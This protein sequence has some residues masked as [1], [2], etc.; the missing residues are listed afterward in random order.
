M[1]WGKG[2]SFKKRIFLG[3][4]LAAMA[5]L[6]CS[7]VTSLLLF[8]ASADREMIEGGT[9]QLASAKERFFLMLESC[10]AACRR[11][12]ENGYTAWAMIDNKTIDWQRDLYLAMYQEAEKSYHDADYSIYDVGGQL[13][14]TTDPSQKQERLP[15]Q[16]GILRKASEQEGMVCSRTEPVLDVG[17]SKSL[18]QAA[19][20]LEGEN[21]VK[22]GYVVVDFTRESLD[23]LLSG[24]L[25]PGNTLL[26]LDSHQRPIYCSNQSYGNEQIQ[27]IISDTRANQKKHSSSGIGEK[28]LWVKEP[29]Y[30]FYILMCCSSLVSEAT[31]RTMGTVS[32]ILS[33]LG[34]GISFVIAGALSRSMGKPVSQLDRAMARVKEGDFS[35][36]ISSSRQDELGRLTERFNEMTGD[37]KK[38]LDDRV[39][40][41]K[42]MNQVNLKLYQTQLNPHFLYNTLDSIRWDAR[43]HQAPEIAVMAENL[44]VILRK[45]IS[46]SPFVTLEEELGMIQSYIEIQKIR[47]SG[48]FCYETEI[49]DQLELCMI[50]KMI[51]QP[52]VENAI[53]HG[54]DGCE[55]GYI[56]IYAFQSGSL[57]CLSVTDNGRGMSKEME[58]WINSEDPDKREGHLGLYNVINIMKIYYGDQSGIHASVTEE[59]T[60]VT[61]RLPAGKEAPDV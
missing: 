17:A 48:S 2:V 55:S 14:F 1:R 42:D 29:S 39:Q 57:L 40:Q 13:R 15:T 28:Y 54:L 38:H 5:P 59:G 20:P 11:L 7:G 19:C 4:I 8:T 12:T 45:S 43:I 56:C 31:V 41:Q 21:G 52:L 27:K 6:I 50:P 49:P 30:G 9:A 33:C 35:I 47:F 32:L 60:T 37:L 10:G 61:L 22:T 26:L 36:R 25:S 34:L 46:G 44:A 53:L 23:H 51:L 24:I 3:C 58:D 16:W 18:L